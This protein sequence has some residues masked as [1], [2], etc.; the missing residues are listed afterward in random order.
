MCMHRSLFEKDKLLFSFLLCISIKAHIDSSVDL[1]E[2]RFL[3]TGGI[4]VQ[5]PPRNPTTWLPEK[6]WAEICRLSNLSAFHGLMQ[7]LTE[8]PE[9]FKRIYDSPDPATEPLPCTWRERQANR[10]KS[11]I[12]RPSILANSD[13]KTTPTFYEQRL[14]RMC[15]LSG[16]QH[17]LIL[18][19]LRP[20][21]LV[22]GIL[23][24]VKKEMGQ[25]Y[26]ESPPFDLQQCF[27]DSTAL[28]PMIFVLSPG[29]DP[30]AALLKFANTSKI[31]ASAQTFFSHIQI[32]Y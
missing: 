10:F 17:L 28:T 5:D 24:Y 26:I 30:M 20:D 4:S 27:Q 23:L 1:T 19:A 25:K 31:E 29:S 12:P 16:F 18:R 14:L 3:L 15:R 9:T 6:L 7:D 11:L 13:H 32:R 21:N 2:F 22:R 8:D